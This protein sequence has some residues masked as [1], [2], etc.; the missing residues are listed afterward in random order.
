MHYT[1]EYTQPT[2]AGRM[3]AALA[4]AK[5]YLGEDTVNTLI[6]EFSKIPLRDGIKTYRLLLSLAGL[7]GA[8]ARAIY[9]Q[10]LRSRKQQNMV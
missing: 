2:K 3:E 5:A 8:P 4:S 10:A 7:Q 6:E 9:L 1:I